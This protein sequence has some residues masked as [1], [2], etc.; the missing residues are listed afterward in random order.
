MGIK[1]LGWNGILAN[2]VGNCIGWYPGD[3]K[4][5]EEMREMKHQGWNG[6]GVKQ[7]ENEKRRM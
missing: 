2:W 3:E 4:T 1:R 7:G 6:Y 5:R